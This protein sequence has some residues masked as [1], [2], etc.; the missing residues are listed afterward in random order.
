MKNK[1]CKITH[2]KRNIGNTWWRL[3]LIKFVLTHSRAFQGFQWHLYLLA[4]FDSYNGMHHIEFSSISIINFSFFLPK[5]IQQENHWNAYEEL[6]QQTW[7]TKECKITK[8]KGLLFSEVMNC[9]I[10][11]AWDVVSFNLNMIHLKVRNYVVVHGKGDF[12]S[13]RKCVELRMDLVWPVLLVML[14][15]K[16]FIEKEISPKI[17]LVNNIC[18]RLLHT[19]S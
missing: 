17:W 6:R 18:W 1:T 15:A 13:L 19:M 11:H 8:G 7:S 5:P 2:G 14:N 16:E 10:I 4:M 3:G 9:S 12:H